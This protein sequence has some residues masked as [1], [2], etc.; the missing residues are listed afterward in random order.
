[1]FFLWLWKCGQLMYARVLSSC[2][3]P[4]D[5]ISAPHVRPD[6]FSQRRNKFATSHR[7]C[8]FQTQYIMT[9][10]RLEGQERK[11]RTLPRSACG[12]KSST[13]CAEQ[14][15]FSMY[16]EEMISRYIHVVGEQLAH[17]QHPLALTWHDDD[18]GLWWFALA[19]SVRSDGIVR[20]DCKMFGYVYKSTSR[21]TG[22]G[23]QGLRQTILTKKQSK[24]IELIEII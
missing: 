7:L 19:S 10:I 22:R 21:S 8:I 4:N 17:G 1:M 9:N 16:M 6:F 20:C 23:L 14:N 11:A 12:R 3:V 5:I 2:S 24:Q 18:D 13:D 15:N